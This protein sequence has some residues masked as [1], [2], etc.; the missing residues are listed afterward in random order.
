MVGDLGDD[1]TPKVQKLFGLKKA[2]D[3]AL[4]VEN[5]KGLLIELTSITPSVFPD[6][7]LVK[8]KIIKNFNNS[9]S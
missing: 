7:M 8:D 1:R 6:F 2:G 3:K 5:G 4:A 9:G